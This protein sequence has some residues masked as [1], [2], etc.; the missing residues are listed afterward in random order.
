MGD[1]SGN[2]LKQRLDAGRAISLAVI[3]VPGVAGMQ[4]WAHAGI[5]ALIVDMEHG[6]IDIET[7]HG[8]VAATGGTPA[9][10]LV[11]IPWNVPWLAKPVLDT[12]AMGLVFPMIA[13]A[14]DADAAIRSVRYPPRGERGWG[15]FFA[16]MRWNRTIP[17]YVARADDELF[18]VLL[19]ERPEAIRN[20][21][22]IARVDGI[23]MFVIAPFDLAVTMGYPNQREHPA[24]QD[25]IVEAERKILASGVPLCGAA[26]TPDA[27]NQL[28]ERGYRG[29]FVG[30]DWMLM[31][32]A[33]ASILGGVQLDRSGGGA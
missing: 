8:M 18:T 15:P 21:A 2:P 4:V 23:D 30:F 27:A 25:A 13:D 33:A 10:P 12:G 26:F 17:E 14:Q 24:V 31:Q 3:T 20:L 7:V 5:D 28:L 32:R 1:S 11:R 29:V 19:I 16:H 6:A 9:V 22:S